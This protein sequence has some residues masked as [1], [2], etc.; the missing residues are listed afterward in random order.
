MG[1]LALPAPVSQN[2]EASSCGQAAGAQ[3]RQMVEKNDVQRS[4]LVEEKQG[5]T[6]TTY[7]NPAVPAQQAHPEDKDAHQRGTKDKLEVIPGASN[8]EA[9][10]R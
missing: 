8:G 9:W 6:P 2:P 4:G 1:Q 3:Q 5:V 10:R 7:I